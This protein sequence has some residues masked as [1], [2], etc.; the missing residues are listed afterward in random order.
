[1][2]PQDFQTYHT[3]RAAGSPE[4]GTHLVLWCREE[5]IT[6]AALKSQSAPAASLDGAF[7]G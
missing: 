4:T 2:F 5:A 6:R 1:M 7:F 3:V